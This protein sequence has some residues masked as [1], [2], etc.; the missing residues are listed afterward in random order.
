MSWIV[1]IGDGFSLRHGER[2]TFNYPVG[3]SSYAVMLLDC[4]P[5]PAPAI[6]YADTDQ[7]STSGLEARANHA[8]IGAR[9][10]PGGWAWNSMAPDTKES[11]GILAEQTFP[12]VPHGEWIGFDLEA[13]P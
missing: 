8:V 6:G 3:D 9:R 7:A 12:D 4:P 11:L 10:T 1:K 5:P 2:V 13:S